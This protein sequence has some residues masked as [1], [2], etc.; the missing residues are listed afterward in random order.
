MLSNF[1]FKPYAYGACLGSFAALLTHPAL[2]IKIILSWH[3][4]RYAKNL[5]LHAS[6]DKLIMSSQYRLYTHFFYKKKLK[7][8][9]TNHVINVKFTLIVIIRIFFNAFCHISL[10][11]FTMEIV[12]IF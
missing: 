7:F 1:D 5:T 2:I 11:D 9:F 6:R 12:A 8:T 4:Y 3:L 10:H